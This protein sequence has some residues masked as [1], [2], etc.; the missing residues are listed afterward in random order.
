MNAFHHLDHNYNTSF[1]DYCG[2][3]ASQKKWNFLQNILLL[4]VLPHLL[5]QLQ[6]TQSLFENI[7]ATLNRISFVLHSLPSHTNPVSLL[8]ILS[9]FP[10]VIYIIST[11][12]PPTASTHHHHDDGVVCC[13]GRYGYLFQKYT[14]VIR[15]LCQRYKN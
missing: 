5:L 7:M 12:T 15:F 4:E 1:C 13:V 10:L 8:C 3:K 14:H 9:R 11:L 2:V 6:I